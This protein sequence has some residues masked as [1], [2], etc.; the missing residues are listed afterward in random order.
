MEPVSE[1]SSYMVGKA[2]DQLLDMFRAQV[3][4][5]WSRRRAEEFFAAFAKAVVDPAMPPNEV[6]ADLTAILQD[7]TKSEVLFDAYRRVC[8]AKS[9]VI[10]P[11]AIGLLTAQILIENRAATE[12]EERWF[13]AY[14]TC[15]DEEL[16]DLSEFYAL[17]FERLRGNQKDYRVRGTT[18]QIDWTEDEGSLTGN[19][20]R[21]PLNLHEALGSWAAKLERLGMIR[22][23]MEEKIWDRRPH[24]EVPDHHQL[25]RKLVYRIY[26]D[27][28]D[29]EYAALIRRAIPKSI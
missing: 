28:P 2:A 12:F 9:K 18:M 26:F 25:G 6:E 13:E 27:L 5:R 20:D 3:I 14:E 1:I 29:E 22:T 15:S 21:S 19:V 24:A 4:E 23:T 10:G 17:A 8:L 7:E 11:R 16:K